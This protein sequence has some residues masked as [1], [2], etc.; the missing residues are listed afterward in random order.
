MGMLANSLAKIPVPSAQGV[1]GL[2]RLI[3]SI[4][5][6]VDSA[7]QSLLDVPRGKRASPEELAKNAADLSE[8][9]DLRNSWKLARADNNTEQ[10]KILAKQ[11]DEI[12][13]RLLAA[14]K[15]IDVTK[16]SSAHFHEQ[17]FDSEA[18][19]KLPTLEAFLQ[20]RFGGAK[21]DKATKVLG[22]ETD[23]GVVVLSGIFIKKVKLERD[24]NG[25]AHYRDIPG[26]VGVLK[27]EEPKRY[28][29]AG[30][31]QQ[32]AVILYTISG[33]PVGKAGA[34]LVKRLADEFNG[35]VLVSTLSP[36]RELY[37]DIPKEAF[38]EMTGTDIKQC[39]L[40]YLSKGKDPVA[41]FHLGNGAMIGDIN[42]NLHDPIDPITINYIYSASVYERETMSGLFLKTK[43][44]HVAGHLEEHA[45]AAGV[46]V[47]VVSDGDNIPAR[48]VQWER[49]KQNTSAVKM[50]QA[51]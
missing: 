5:D 22:L 2:F 31:N 33:G 43:A 25:K 8:Y 41:N 26:H 39:V 21:D 44:L 17:L 6:A 35:A 11:L 49:A 9:A 36:I 1:L 3:T 27:D 19:H 18:V 4:N 34:E 12:G 24:G 46:K 47:N 10:A 40:D 15:L 14:A 29:S 48:V 51:A 13:A 37:K 32:D 28:K 50:P 23:S 16:K 30:K 42:I 20:K 38:S 7:R 45:A